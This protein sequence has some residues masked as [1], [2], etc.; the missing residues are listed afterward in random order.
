[1]VLKRVQHWDLNK[2]TNVDISL[3]FVSSDLVAPLLLV[4]LFLTLL[5]SEDHGPGSSTNREENLIFNITKDSHTAST[6]GGEK[7]A[8]ELSGKCMFARSS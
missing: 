3:V 7:V 8:N 1:M 2:T 6:G 4:Y 5:G